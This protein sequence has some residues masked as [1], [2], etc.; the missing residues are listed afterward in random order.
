MTNIEK[1]HRNSKDGLK[2]I[3][4]EKRGGLNVR[5]EVL[6]FLVPRLLAD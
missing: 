6:I 5:L 4:E 3:V 1:L 2:D